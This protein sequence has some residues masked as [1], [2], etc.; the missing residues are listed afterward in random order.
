MAEDLQ[1]INW[2]SF[3]LAFVGGYSDAASLLLAKTFTGHVTGNFILT[4]ISIAAHDWQNFTRRVLAIALFLMG[5]ILSVILE[6]VLTKNP[7]QSF[8]PIVLGLEI[9]LILLAY[10]ALTSLL[11][12][13]LDCSHASVL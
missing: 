6:R 12:A 7:W 5:I 8:L 11:G 2:L 13:R 10:V 1:N 9:V 4:A 3:G